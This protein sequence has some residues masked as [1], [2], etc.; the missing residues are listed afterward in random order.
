MTISFMY[1]VAVYLNTEYVQLHLSSLVLKCVHWQGNVNI[2]HVVLVIIIIIRIFKDFNFN[3]LQ[4]S[5]KLYL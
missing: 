2:K 1:A 5:L 3:Q 4:S